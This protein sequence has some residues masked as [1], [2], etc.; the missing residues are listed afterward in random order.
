MTSLDFG[1]LVLGGNVF[2][3]TAGRD[4][5][6]AVLDAFVAGGGV[7]IDT[8]DSYMQRVPGNNGG[9]SEA[10]IGEWIA[11]RGNRDRVQVHTK[12]FGKHDR[13]GLSAG[14][15]AGAIDDSLR[16]L[17]TDHVDLY[18]AH[19]DDDSVAQEEYVAA[20]DALVRAGK[21]REVGASN[22]SAARLTSALQ[23]AESAS[24]TPFTVAQDHWN[25]VE[26]DLETELVPTLR[27]H[28]IVELPYYSLASGFL[29]GKYRPGQDVDSVRAQSAKGYLERPG[30][31][32]LL[33]A[34]DEVA[35]AHD[36]SVAA[37]SLAWLRAQDPVG[38]PIASARTLEQVQ[39]LLDSAVVELAADELAR[40]TEVSDALG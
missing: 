24:L 15:I 16:R 20:F 9:E 11:S 18:Y 36:T 40:L 7:A 38:A 10:I 32:Q 17:Q 27:E 22:F 25:L 34:L 12:V 30:A 23:V 13:A 21:V 28:G 35:E 39:P 4:T 3:W 37:V 31:S 2:G 33:A 1:S 6:F 5:S 19:R 14:N 29:T 8:A 26:R